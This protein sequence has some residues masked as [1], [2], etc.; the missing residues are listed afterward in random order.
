M[1][2]ENAP[3]Q[4]CQ[5]TR[6][7]HVLGQDDNPHFSTTSYSHQ[8][9]SGDPNETENSALTMTN[10]TSYQDAMLRTDVIHWK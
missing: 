3:T 1:A 7:K 10:P 9:S 6:I 8:K 5:S 2:V 4:L